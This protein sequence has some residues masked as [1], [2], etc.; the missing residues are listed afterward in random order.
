MGDDGRIGGELSAAQFSM[1]RF[2]PFGCSSCGCLDCHLKEIDRMTIESTCDRCLFSVIIPQKGSGI[3]IAISDL[4]LD[5]TGTQG[6]RL[7]AIPVVD[8][9][10]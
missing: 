3:L 4:N 5:R 6:D 1:F 7:R 10:F 8:F 9:I 2:N